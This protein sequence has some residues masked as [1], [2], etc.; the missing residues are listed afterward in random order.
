MISSGSFPPSEQP[1]SSRRRQIKIKIK[2]KV[3]VKVEV[4]VE[5]EVE[6]EDIA[7]AILG[8]FRNG[9]KNYRRIIVAYDEQIFARFRP[10]CKR[11]DAADFAVDIE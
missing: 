1:E 11:N 7:W 6:V 2:I 5:A 8:D 10:G 4:E 9:L 3:E